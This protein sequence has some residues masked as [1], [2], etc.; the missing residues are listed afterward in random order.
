MRKP[1]SKCQFPWENYVGTKLSLFLVLTTF[2]I[3]LITHMV[4]Q[5]IKVFNPLI[6]NHNRSLMRYKV[7]KVWHINFDIILLIES[8]VIWNFTSFW[9]VSVF[10]TLINF[11]SKNLQNTYHITDYFLKLNKRSPIQFLVKLMR[12]DIISYQNHFNLL[13]KI[14]INS[15]RA[16][17]YLTCLKWN[18]LSRDG[19]ILEIEFIF[20]SNSQKSF[21]I[22]QVFLTQ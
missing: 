16:A 2:Y 4:M 15:Q 7:I 3:C 19:I 5:L 11:V 9:I 12:L 22:L 13:Q 20:L 17:V 1:K 6:M 8:L 10:S 18:T 21:C 14:C